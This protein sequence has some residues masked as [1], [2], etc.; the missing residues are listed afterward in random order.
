MLTILFEGKLK[1][2]EIPAF[3]AA[4][5]EKA[6]REH[7]IFHNHK[8]DKN[9]FF[10]YPII[11]YK[12]IQSHPAIQCIEDGVDGIHHFF[13]K[14]DWTLNINKN[15]LPI[16]VH[17]LNMYQFNMQVWDKSFRYNIRN[18]IA[19]NQNNYKKYNSIESLSERI[20]MLE[21]L[22][23]GNILTLAKG[24]NWTVDKEIKVSILEIQRVNTVILKDQAVLGFNLSF[25]CNVGL[26]DYIGLGKSVSVGY[27]MVFK[28]REQKQILK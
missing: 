15:Q 16:L 22:L 10:R 2:S 7:D 6:G 18:W 8:D 14:K 25:T 17:K 26:P 12:Q 21:A 24:I 4:I 19:L 23:R 3:R 11:Q 28:I 5:I 20:S 9:F 13:A 1:A 27:G